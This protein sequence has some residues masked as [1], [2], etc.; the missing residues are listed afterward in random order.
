MQYHNIGLF[1]SSPQK[2]G[3]ALNLGKAKVVA[4]NLFAYLLYWFC[5]ATNRKKGKAK[6]WN[7]K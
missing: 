5:K 1:S 2:S 4:L 3:R 6:N 7:K